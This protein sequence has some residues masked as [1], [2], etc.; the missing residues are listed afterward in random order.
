MNRGERRWLAATGALATIAVASIARADCAKDT[1]CKGDRICVEGT[2]ADPE[3]RPS[4]SGRSDADHD[5]AHA[6]DTREPDA[7]LEP[8]NPAM[9]TAGIVLTS[10]GIATFVTAMALWIDFVVQSEQSTTLTCSQGRCEVPPPRQPAD[11]A[12]A[13]LAFGLATPAL[14][15]AGIPLWVVGGRRVPRPKAAAWWVPESVSLAGKRL[16]LTFGF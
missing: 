11:V 8:R 15:G 1:D 10:A 2:C 7:P 12:A 9:K 4:A 13:A 5:D 3:D 14:L 16:T 6:D